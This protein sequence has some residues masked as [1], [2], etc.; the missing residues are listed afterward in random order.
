MSISG[1]VD[2]REGIVGDAGTAPPVTC[3]RQFEVLVGDHGDAD[4]AAGAAGDFLLRCAVS[5]VKVPPP[6]VP[7]PSSP[8]LMGFISRFS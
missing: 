8:T 5:T 7:M 4:R 6:T 2:H 1:S 3:L